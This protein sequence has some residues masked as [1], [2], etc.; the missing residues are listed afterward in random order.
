M[1]EDLTIN[2]IAPPDY[3]RGFELGTHAGE[4]ER[5][6]LRADL[7]TAQAIR[8]DFSAKVREQQARLR[9]W[10]QAAREMRS[11]HGGRLFALLD[12]LE[13]E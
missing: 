9:E 8:A 1:S 10:E 2:V 6:H 3:W 4:A 7:E 12:S 11:G 13:R 5:A